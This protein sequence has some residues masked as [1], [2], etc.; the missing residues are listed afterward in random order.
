MSGGTKSSNTSTSSNTVDPQSMA[1]LQGNYQTAQ[2][3][4]ASLAAPYTGQLTA[5]FNPTQT[6]AQGVLSAIG[7]NPIYGQNAGGAVSAANGV[8][9]SNP[10]SGA[11]LAQYENPYTS[12]VINTSVAQNERAR[13]TANTNDNQVATAAGAFGGSRSGVANALTNQFYDQNDQSNIA[14]LNSANF[15]QAQTAALNAS[16]LKLSAADNVANLNNNALQSATAQ[17]GVLGAVGDAQQGQSQTELTTAYNA[18]LQGQQLTID[19]QNLLNSALGMIPVQQTV[20][21]SGT[22]S[23]TTNPGLAGYMTAAGSLFSGIGKL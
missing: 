5:G 19:Q 12:D 14:N 2:G 17:A 15:S 18:W 16:N 9:N 23:T 10:L 11:N 22:G 1:L 8:L 7:T 6:Q 21:S 13:Q 20:N 3:N 4:A